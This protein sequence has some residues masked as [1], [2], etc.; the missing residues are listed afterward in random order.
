MV[1]CCSL[2]YS[3]PSGSSASLTARGEAP[4]FFPN[5]GIKKS[6]QKIESV[7]IGAL[8][9]GKGWL[10]FVNPLGFTKSRDFYVI[11]KPQ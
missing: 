3:L 4:S 11:F 6:F 1:K 8:S 10:N 2:P 7:I 9:F 5:C